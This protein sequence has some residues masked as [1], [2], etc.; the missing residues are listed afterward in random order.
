[1]PSILIAEDN[2]VSLRFQ[3]EAACAAGHDVEAARDG[4]QAL[5][6]ASAHR[7]DLLLLDLIMPQLGGEE[8]LHGV[9]N[10]SAA[11]SRHAMAIA[12]SAELSPERIIALRAAGFSDTLAKPITMHALQAALQRNLRGEVSAKPVS[13]SQATAQQDG[14]HARH[15]LLDDAAALSATGDTEVMTALRG[16]F[17]RELRGLPDELAQWRRQ[18]NL[19]AVRDRLHRL[20]ASCGFCGAPALDAAVA[21]LR[22][23]LDGRVMPSGEAFVSLLELAER[24]RA[25]LSHGEE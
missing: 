9:R 12:T 5:R 3:C 4:A 14:A 23:R 11:A 18:N 19:V 7:F 24:T 15:M 22:R 2:P 16:L 8:V 17:A 21:T 25:L 6:L 20:R 10:D 1:M 13:A